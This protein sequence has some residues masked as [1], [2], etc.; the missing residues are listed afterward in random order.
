MLTDT[1]NYNVYSL[2]IEGMKQVRWPGLNNARIGAIFLDEEGV[3]ISKYNMAVNH[4]LFDFVEGDYIFIDVPQGAKNF[5]F[6]SKA[7]NNELEAIAVDSSEIE[8]IEPDW[9]ENKPWLGGVYHAS[10]DSLTQLRSISGANVRCGTGTATTSTEW[11]YDSEGKPTNTPLSA[12]NYT[13]KDFMNLAARRGKGYQLFDYEM[14]KLMAILYFSMTGN[15]DAQFL[16]GYGRGAGGQTGYADSLGNTDSTR[17]QISGNKCLGFESFFGCTWEYM[18]NILRNVPT[19]QQALKDRMADNISTYPIDHKWHIYDPISKTERVVDGI[20]TSGYCIARV[21]HGRYCDI[22][23]SKCST[24]NSV[25][26]KNYC[27]GFYYTQS[28][29]RVVGRSSNRSYA[30]GGLV[31]TYTNFASASS[32]LG[33]RFSARLQRSDKH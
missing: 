29:C 17:G 28:R 33:L 31:F 12:M 21:K 14:S 5:I 2:N 15:R 27:D 16:C 32:D 7:T 8:A 9:V 13:G 18:D 6:A 10:M 30:G 24:D 20:T 4:T 23:P 19:Y 11:Q 25:W 22:I 1:P 3:I 26:A